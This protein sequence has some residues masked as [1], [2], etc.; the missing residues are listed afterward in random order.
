[1]LISTGSCCCVQDIVLY[2]TVAQLE[3]GTGRPINGRL[4][5]INPVTGTLL[6][7]LHSEGTELGSVVCDPTT[8]YIY[9]IHN[10]THNHLGSTVFDGVD[11]IALDRNGNVIWTASVSATTGISAIGL[12]VTNDGW[13]YIGVGDGK[14][15]K[16][17]AATGTQNTTGWPYNWTN[18]T[19]ISGY[20]G[21]CVDQSG[22]V[23]GSGLS[24][25]GTSIPFDAMRALKVT[26]AGVLS[27][28]SKVDYV[29]GSGDSGC[30]GVS[31]NVAGTQLAISGVN[32]TAQ[33]TEYLVNASTGAVTGSVLRSTQRAPTAYGPNVNEVYHGGLAEASGYTISQNLGN[34]FKT[35]GNTVRGLCTTRVGSLYAT[36]TAS[37]NGK[38]VWGIL[39]GWT[40]SEGSNVITG[41]DIETSQGR[42]GAFGL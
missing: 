9:V 39:E 28:Q 26:P 30:A 31:V 40:Y 34:Y 10:L 13:V 7:T 38:L 1:M 42:I 41:R 8:G 32:S 37:N 29:A 27:W 17:N 12:A 20:Q 18:G 15:Y 4:L 11:L 21:I 16:Y 35:N 5:E 3:S 22:N 2:V 14:I 19:A 23:Y 33:K 36:T 6:R 24:R 25:I